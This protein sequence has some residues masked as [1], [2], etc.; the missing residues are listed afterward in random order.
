MSLLS[1]QKL[2]PWVTKDTSC[3]PPLPGPAGVYGHSSVST[4]INS[5][6]AT[7]L[8]TDVV[9]AFPLLPVCGQKALKQNQST[10]L[11]PVSSLLRS[12]VNKEFLSHCLS[13]LHFISSAC[14]YLIRQ[15]R[16]NLRSSIFASDVLDRLPFLLSF[17][18]PLGGTNLT[19]S[20]F[21]ESIV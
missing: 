21:R 9:D 5:S 18:I 2:V 12:Q 1:W 4:S 20:R 6:A 14:C 8:S 17:T 3:L 19:P 13:S 15:E 11:H 16:L 7:T 10:H